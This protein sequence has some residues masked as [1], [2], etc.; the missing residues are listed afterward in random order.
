MQT[1]VPTGSQEP[2]VRI[3]KHPCHV[4]NVPAVVGWLCGVGK[5]SALPGS[6]LVIQDVKKNYQWPTL[7]MLLLINGAV[8]SHY[9]YGVSNYR[10]FTCLFN[11]LSRAKNVK[12]P[13]CWSL[14]GETTGGFSSQTVIKAENVPILW[15]HREYLLSSIIFC[16]R[17][18]IFSSL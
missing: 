17:S 4:C 18:L 12:T 7:P 13:H 9:Q 15:R 10:L 2:R 5:Y 16:K 1:L 8:T 14:W 11:R 3:D 6:R